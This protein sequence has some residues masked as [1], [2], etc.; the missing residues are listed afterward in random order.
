MIVKT[1][2]EGNL[3]SITHFWRVMTQHLILIIG[4]TVAVQV[5]S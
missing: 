4:C 2:Q 3:R 5:E 1:E